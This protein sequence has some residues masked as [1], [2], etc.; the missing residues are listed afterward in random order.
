MYGN[1]GSATDTGRALCF[2]RMSYEAHHTSGP[3]R[4]RPR[5]L[6]DCLLQASRLALHRI[7]EPPLSDTPNESGRG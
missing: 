2:E 5:S 3:D 7:V 4:C 6:G 1:K